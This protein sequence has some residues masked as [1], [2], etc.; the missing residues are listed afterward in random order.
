VN[1]AL[2]GGGHEK[3]GRGVPG[4]A[5]RPWKGGR[6]KGRM[7][8]LY[9]PFFL[10]T[11][12]ERSEEDMGRSGSYVCRAES[13]R[14]NKG[15]GSHCWYFPKALVFA[16]GATSRWRESGK[17]STPEEGRGGRKSIYYQGKK[18]GPVL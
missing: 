16:I 12:A 15:T 14:T 2:R 5:N 7:H 6:L 13:K 9:L 18:V 3:V 10:Q 11:T 17:N 4:D 8:Y 1:K